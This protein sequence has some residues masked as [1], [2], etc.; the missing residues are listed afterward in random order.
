MIR[1]VSGTIWTIR[2]TTTKALR[3][4]K[5]NRARAKAARAPTTSDTRTVPRP[6]TTLER[7]LAQK[8]SVPSARAK[9]SSVNRP[10]QNSGGRRRISEAGRNAVSTIQ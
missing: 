3:P 2:I 6:M 5:R 10:G 7:T 4:A 8:V 1:A 9:L